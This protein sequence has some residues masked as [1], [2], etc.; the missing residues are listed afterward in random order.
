M[1]IKDY[2]YS[3][4]YKIS[5]ECFY[6]FGLFN[7]KR[8]I[9]I[10]YFFDQLKEYKKLNGINLYYIKLDNVIFVDD[11][12]N[13]ILNTAKYYSN[14]NNFKDDLIS[15]PHDF[16]IIKNNEKQSILYFNDNDNDNNDK[17]NE[18]MDTFFNKK[19]TI[20]NNS[21]YSFL[22]YT[23]NFNDKQ[24][25]IQLQDSYY[26]FCFIGNNIGHKYFIYWYLDYKYQLKLPTI[27]DFKYSITLIDENADIQENL[28]CKNIL[29]EKSNYIIN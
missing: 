20:F 9:Y 26:D 15:N 1:T 27:N 23:I 10:K 4:M 24:Y 17:L 28:Q 13:G 29:L 22:S 3:L 8:K 18:L 16:I 21:E 2:I 7:V 19:E 5:Y 6:Y 11:E 12:H 25:E 14:Y